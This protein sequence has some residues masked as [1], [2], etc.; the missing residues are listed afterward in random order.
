MVLLTFSLSA[1]P[2]PEVRTHVVRLRNNRFVPAE[3]RARGGDTLRFVNGEG[4][5]HNVEFEK[6]SIA[7]AA[8]T[9]IAAAMAGKKIGPMSSPLLILTDE[10]YTIVVPDLPAGR[11]PLLCT[12]HYGNMRGALVVER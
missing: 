9:L 11:Y 1:L 10:S 4:G 7:P 6:D 8:R 2:A 5:I 12:P 3:I